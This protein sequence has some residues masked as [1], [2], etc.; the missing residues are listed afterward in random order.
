LI[1]AWIAAFLGEPL[2]AQN[3]RV[4]T[5]SPKPDFSAVREFINAEMG[6]GTST[7]SMAVAV[8]RGNEILWEEGFGSIDRPGGTS[9]T[10]QTLYYT[11]SVTKAITATALM[12]L[13]ERK[14]LDL[15]RPANLYLK[16]AKLRS[17]HWNPDQV[18]VRQLATHTAGLA[19]YDGWEQIPADETI[20]RYGVVFWRPADHFDYSN[21]GF[22]ILGQI[23]SDVSG[24]SFQAFVHDEVLRPLA[25]ENAWAGAMP[26]SQYPVAPRYSSLLRGFSPALTEPTLPGASVLYSSAHELALF[27]MLHLKARRP[28]QKALL[29]DAGIDGLQEPSVPV[30]NVRH[31]VAWLIN[32]NQAWLLLVPS[33]KMIVVV[34]ANAGNVA[35]TRLIDQI[36]S[37]LLPTY[38]ENLARAQP[39]ATSATAP[40]ATAVRAVPTEL[41]GLW[42]GKI[43]TYRADLPVA[44]TISSDGEVETRLGK[45]AAVKMTNVRVSANR[46]VGRMLGDLG[47]DYADGAPYELRFEL[48]R[49]G[50]KLIGAAVTYAVP[51]RDGPR[52][53]FWVELTPSDQR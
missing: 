38:S 36:L 43:Q 30:G 44:F 7:P 40:A 4:S 52:L 41:V 42:S 2:I 16:A 31:S 3:G 29:S 49:D 19:T 27:G 21:L 11:G 37:L 46:V 14:Q 39:P 32:D 26:Q 17:P 25:M 9:A 48:Y 18:T 33:E 51:G 35:A 23:I 28:D 12:I 47:I 13:S 8:A 53:P 10:A 1:A 15:D 24:R 5:P 20:R 6:V 22:G 45:Q 50:N 34:L